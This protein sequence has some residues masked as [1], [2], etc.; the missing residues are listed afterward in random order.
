MSADDDVDVA[1]WRTV[2]RDQGGSGK[3]S[4]V[5]PKVPAD[6]KAHVSMARLVGAFATRC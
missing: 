3:C 2:G 4:N 6:A 1:T 5:S